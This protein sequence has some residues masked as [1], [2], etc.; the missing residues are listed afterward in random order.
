MNSDEKCGRRTLVY[1]SRQVWKRGLV[2]GTSGNLSVRLKDGSFL[3]T[4]ARQSLRKLCERDIVR[5]DEAG[6]ATDRDTLPSSELALHLATYSVR[7]GVTAIVHSHP[8]FCVVWS[9]FGTTFPCETVGARETLGELAWTAYAAPGTQELANLVA[10]E[11]SRG[12]DAVLMENHGLTTVGATL[13]DAFVLTD[14]AEE[15]ARVA[16]FDGQ[17]AA[18]QRRM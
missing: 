13:E 15:S 2:S 1:Y 18:A 8:T 5:V 4:P 16:Y 12:V 10:A 11:F 9:S 6:S 17:G 3:V 14:V 7:P